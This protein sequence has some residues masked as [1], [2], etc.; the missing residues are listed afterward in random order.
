MIA[1]RAGDRG[2]FLEAVEVWRRSN[3]A[4]SNRPVSP[5]HEK[6]VL[7]YLD[8]E[9]TFLVVA[10]DGGHLVGMAIGMQGLEDDGAGPPIQGL[11]H[12]SMVFVSPERWGEGIGG[13]IMDSVLQEAI[14]RGY[15]KVQ[16]WTHV[17]NE[18]GQSLYLSKGF[19]PSGRQKQDDEGDAIMHLDRDL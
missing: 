14:A 17:G 8:T 12:I 4:R 6:R 5:D 16:L 2:D 18:R 3:E 1:I 7:G 9:N 11:C 19:A 13:Q 15:S 10:E